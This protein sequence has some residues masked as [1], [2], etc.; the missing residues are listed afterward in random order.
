MNVHATRSATIAAILL[1]TVTASAHAQIG[2]LLKKGKDAAAGKATESAAAQVPPTKVDVLPCAVTYDQLTALEKGLQAELDA[3]PSAKKEAEQRQK[4]IESEQKGYDKALADYNKKNEAWG[5]CRDKVMNDPVA[6]QKA[7]AASAKSEAAAQKAAGA[8]D[9]QQMMAMA[10]KAQAAAQRVSNGTA[11]AADRQT[12]ADY[13]A[14][15]AKVSQAG[16]AAIAG[17]QEEQALSAEQQARLAKCGEEPKSPTAPSQLGW[18]PERVLLETGAKAAG[19]DP[20]TYLAVRDCAIKS[21][22]LRLKD[23]NPDASR[24]NPKLD[25]VQNT[26]NQMRSAKVPI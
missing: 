25:E 22:N 4:D 10:E 5:S 19:M 23:G 18:S 3:A 1:A 26:L 24:M 9:E 11:T 14:Y 21:A 16:N 6:R 15:M 7:E 20:A 8:V 12:L 17:A 2:G 13:Q